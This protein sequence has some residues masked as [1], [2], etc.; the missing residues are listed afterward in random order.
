MAPVDDHA[1]ATGRPPPAADLIARLRA[2]IAARRRH[3]AAYEGFRPAAVLLPMVARDDGLALLFI[4][5]TADL[6]SHGGQVAFPGGKLDDCDADLG[7]CAVREATEELGL[8][9]RGIEQLGLLDDVPTPSRFVITPVV[10]MLASEPHIRP[11][12]G[13]VASWFYV[14]LERL[15]DPAC[16]E[17]QGNRE[18]MGISY[19][20]L[21]YRVDGRVIWGATARMVR[22][23]LELAY[24][25]PLAA[26]ADEGS[27]R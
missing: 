12:P 26:A 8:E 13:E 14:S 4:E 17:I 24:P 2:A 20:M 18:L 1:A 22:Q 6:P 11:N 10:G 15:R 16:Q 9:A 19:P 21:A 25:K 27:L 7:A 23:L 3:L 5:R